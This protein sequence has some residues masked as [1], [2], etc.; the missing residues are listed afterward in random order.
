M[1]EE[2]PG[3]WELYRGIKDLRESV[4]KMSTGMVTQAMFLLYQQGQDA[5]NKRL[6][7]RLKDLETDQADQR[8]TKQQQWFA[9]GISALGAV[10]SLVVGVVLFNV[11][12]GA[13]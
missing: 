9:I 12:G 10:G 1:S 2:E 4:E 7:A 13:P 8:K 3:N 5:E 6:Q 11:R